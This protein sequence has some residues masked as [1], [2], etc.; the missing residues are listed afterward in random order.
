[1]AT[2][3]SDHAWSRLI[4]S[5]YDAALDGSG[6]GWSPALALVGDAV[7]ARNSTVLGIQRE[8]RQFSGVF[9]VGVDAAAGDD[10][11]RADAG[12]THLPEDGRAGAGGAVP[13]RGGAAR[14][15]GSGWRESAVVVSV[16]AARQPRFRNDRP[17]ADRV[18]GPA[19]SAPRVWSWR[20]GPRAL[21]EAVGPSRGEPHHVVQRLAAAR[22]VRPD[23]CAVHLGA[24]LEFL[25]GGMPYGF[26]AEPG[27]GTRGV[28]TAHAARPL[29][30]EF[31]NAEPVIW[32]AVHGDRRGAAVEPPYA[33]APATARSNPPLYQ[34]LTRVDALRVGRA[35]ERQRAKPLLHD[36]LTTASRPP[37]GGTHVHGPRRSESA[38]ARTERRGSASVL[39]RWP[40]GRTRRAGPGH[41]WHAES[42]ERHDTRRRLLRSQRLRRLHGERAP[43]GHVVRSAHV[44]QPHG[45][46]TLEPA[47]PRAVHRRAPERGQ[48]LRLR[49]RRQRPRQ[50]PGIPAA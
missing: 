16:G 42:G 19:Q 9:R 14:D 37:P 41:R 23:T 8:S 20:V 47:Q 30:A 36:R 13:A 43:R 21:A 49:Q 17:E 2:P 31:T 11:D 35:R 12:A 27:A 7:G 5:I 29:A 32:P 10:G 4:A 39:E 3:L 40:N 28:P 26:P 18:A 34:S 48:E 50:R 33:A 38:P 24:L 25:L 1:M 45:R 15:G 44:A 6:E 46:V 22:L